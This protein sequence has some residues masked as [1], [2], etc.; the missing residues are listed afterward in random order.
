MSTLSRPDPPPACVIRC[1]EP[2]E[3]E[4][5]SQ[6]CALCFAAKRPVPPPAW[7][8]ATHVRVDP[9]PHVSHIFVVVDAASG[10]F[11]ATLRI[12]T[13]D[14]RV[15]RGGRFVRAGGVG[16]VCTHPEHRCVV[17]RAAQNRP[18]QQCMRRIVR[19]AGWCL[20]ATFLGYGYEVALLSIVAAVVAPP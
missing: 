20:V 2:S 17:A 14:V 19:S 16:E 6:F 1:L 13:R 4:A 8:F 12:F 5:W 18:R 15:A 11:R 9:S 3:L 10:E 7:R